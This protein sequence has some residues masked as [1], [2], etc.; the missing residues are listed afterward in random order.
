[1]KQRLT[2]EGFKVI[3]QFTVTPLGEGVSVSEFVAEALKEV[4]KSG[5]RFQLTPMSTILEADTLKDALDVVVRAHEA[6][7]KAGA[8]RVVTDLKID[9][10]RDEPR[11][12]EEKV[13]KVKKEL[14]RAYS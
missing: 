7:F 3:A 14:E 8:T 12:M 4:K 10:R 5:L 2:G 6:V 1:M 13:D 9:D 11:Q